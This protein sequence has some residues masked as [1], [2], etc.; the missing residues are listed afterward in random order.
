[1]I[2]VVKPYIDVTPMKLWFGPFLYVIVTTPSDIEV[3]FII[4]L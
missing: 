2:D 1:M 4:R 3:R